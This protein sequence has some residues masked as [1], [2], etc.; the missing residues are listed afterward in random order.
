MTA[1]LWEGNMRTSN[2]T[3]N[4][5]VASTGLVVTSAAEVRSAGAE[6]MLKRHREFNRLNLVLLILLSAW[7]SQP[8]MAQYN[9]GPVVRQ[10]RV[11]QLLWNRSASHP[12]PVLVEQAQIM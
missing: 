8:A 12:D 3:W 2:R 10:P 5:V 4:P 9:G 1:E 6:D 7:L 11:V